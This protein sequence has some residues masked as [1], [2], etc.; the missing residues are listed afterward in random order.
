MYRDIA[1]E[2]LLSQLDSF[3]VAHMSPMLGMSFSR[4]SLTHS[5]ITGLI[6]EVDRQLS[7]ADVVPWMNWHAAAAY[8]SCQ[9]TVAVTAR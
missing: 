6:H 8:T 9:V 2:D 7:R 3:L 4:I 5:I 1:L